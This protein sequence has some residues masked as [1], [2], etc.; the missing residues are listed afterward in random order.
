VST[1][2]HTQWYPTS[3]AL[4]HWIALDT[5]SLRSISAVTVTARPATTGPNGRIGQYT[6]QVSTDGTAWTQVAAGTLGDWGGAQTISFPAAVGRYLKL[7]ALTEAGNRGPWTSAAEVDLTSALPPAPS[8]SATP[9]PTVSPTP[10]ATAS[11]TVSP[12]PSPTAST[13]A[14]G[15]WSA[16]I[17]LPIDPAAAAL[18]SNGKVL[19]WSAYAGDSYGGENG[20]TQTATIDTSTGAVSQRTVSETG[21]DMFCPGVALLSD[22]TLFVAGG[23]NSERQSVYDPVAGTWT[24]VADLK[25]P[26]GYQSA[27]TLSNGK[28]FTLGGSWSGGIGQKN[29]EVWTAGAG[30]GTSAA[31]TGIPVAPFETA[32]AKGE[33]RSDNHMWLFPWS[34]GTV[35]QAGPAKAMHWIDTSGV[36]SYTDA[37][38]RG[39][40]G[41]AMN[42]NAVMYDTGKILTVGGSPSYDSSPA[43]SNAF[44]I[45][46]NGSAPKVSKLAGMA[47]ARAFAN[48]VVLPDG[49]VAVI[50]GQAFAAP[51]S[52]ATSALAPELWDPATKAFTAMAPM[53]IPRN[54]HSFA[55][56]LPDGRVLAGGGQLCANGCPTEHP[57]YEIWTPPYLLDSVGNPRSRPALVTAPKTATAG[58]LLSV[59]TDRPVSGF[60][61]VRM[62][63]A[64][65]SV[66]TDQRRIPLSPIS[67]GGNGYSL[68][69]PSDRGVLLPGE[70]MLFAMDANGT[71][72]TAATVL[73]S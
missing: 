53:A 48:S 18:L 47:N 28:V 11:P 4:P 5:K 67:T 33:F 64:T 45:D 30:G 68:S 29:G 16:V 55:L 14:L 13:G 26:R 38:L 17:S 62:G 71:P 50:G 60:S 51:F 69:L 35:F 3:T 12:T 52:D 8:P 65:H 66:N 57:N 37:G 73:V 41:D 25:T 19:T 1:I 44:T 7:T 21:H 39:D 36:G 43:T 63:S 59:V 27:V 6:V 40:D 15:K 22:G 9:S 56:L 72:S 61:L 54:Y 10:T 23:S 58:G 24:R 20:Y 42:G 32:D 2:W 34:N 49:K 70:W 46:I 31:L